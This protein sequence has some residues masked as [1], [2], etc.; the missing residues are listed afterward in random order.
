MW[1]SPEDFPKQLLGAAP[2]QEMLLVRRSLI[3]ISRRH[4]NAV[5]A[6]LRRVLN[7]T[8][9][10]LPVGGVEQGSVD[11][12][13]KAAIL[14]QLDRGNSPIIDPAVAYGAIMILSVAVQMDRP[15]K[16]RARF[17]QLDLLLEQQRIRAKID[18]L[19][20]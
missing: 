2:I 18:E 5:D 7:K 17:E 10:P 8:G 9:N 16:I 15:G 19:P 13:P 6:D 3:G 12:D 1:V 11:I 20:F 4:G 14:C